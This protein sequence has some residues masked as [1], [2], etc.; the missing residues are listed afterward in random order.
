MKSNIGVVIVTYNRLQKLKKAIESYENQTILPKFMVVVNNNSTDETFSY[1][2]KWEKEKSNISK[3]IVNLSE[4]IGGSGGFYEGIKKAMSLDTNWIW[5]ADDDAYPEND[6]IENSEKHIKE[7]NA[8]EVSAICG[9]VINMDNTI[10]LSHRENIKTNF[11]NIKFY[12]SKL[13]DYKKYS[14][15]INEFSYVGT[16]L[17]KEKLY[18]VGLTNKY[19]FI[20]I[21][22]LEHSYRLSK[23]GKIIC[24]PDIKIYHDYI[25][26]D[27]S[28]T[29]KISLWKYYYDV[30]NRTDFYKR[31]FSKKHFNI[32]YYKRLIL[33]QMRII[34]KKILG[35]PVT[36][37]KVIIEALR[38]GKNGKLGKNNIY[39]QG[40]QIDK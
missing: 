31:Y 35:K 16:I 18:E 22:D 6:V 4:N 23:V 26:K 39:L 2:E 11:F 30:R 28:Y 38:D 27:E 1:L 29:K 40:W 15:E 37:N 8:D 20:H 3:Y 21:D 14:F 36:I 17:N 10:N 13:D 33:Q 12:K 7:I 9:Q 34:I 5:V 24:Y 25:I 32:Y 19:Y